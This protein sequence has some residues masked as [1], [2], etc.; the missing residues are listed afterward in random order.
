MGGMWLV[1]D[2]FYARIHEFPI[3][4]ILTWQPKGTS[5]YR[6]GLSEGF[7]DLEHHRFLE[8]HK[9]V[10]FTES[11]NQWECGHLSSVAKK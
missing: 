7:F 2:F 10:G 3:R 6:S 11:T 9:R 4:V 8:Q 5:S 1:I